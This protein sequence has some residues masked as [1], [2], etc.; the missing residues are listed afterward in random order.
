[1]A[2]ANATWLLL[3]SYVGFVSLGLPDTVLGAA[4]PAVRAEFGLRL[5][6]AGA[7]MLLTT[8]G[9]VL[10]STTSGR[11]RARWGTAVVLIASTIFA[12]LALFVSSVAPSFSVML[13]AAAIA[14]LGGGAI[15]ASLN[16]HVAR[17]YSARHMNWLHA[18]WGVGASTAP[19]IV[20]SVLLAGASWRVAY[21][22]LAVIEALLVI[23]F[24]ATRHSWTDGAATAEEHAAQASTAYSAWP[25]RASVAFFFC[26]GGLEAG[27]GLWAASLLTETRGTSIPLA[28]A[29]VALYWGALCAGRFVIGA[30]A[31]AWQPERVLRISVWCALASTIAFAIPATPTAFVFCALAALG[32]SLASIYPLAMHDT[33]R[34]FGSVTGAHLVGYQ[35]AATAV[36]VACLPWLVGAIASRV[37]L[38][39]LP[40][41]LGVLAVLVTGLERA[42][43]S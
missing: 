13:V 2:R 20:S 4:W 36:G 26:Y 22:V 28:G 10:S 43:R 18:C 24:W 37:S 23:S 5:D 33:P 35:V 34:R 38:E 17:H 1:M 6:Q 30:R 3:L 11:L 9:V 19:A 41:L 16:D 40:A 12:A 29:A 27:A 31:D 25:A 7:A 32:F 8:G 15:D 21:L 39:L 14:G 42:R